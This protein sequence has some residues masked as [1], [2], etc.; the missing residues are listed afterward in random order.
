MYTKLVKK[1]FTK[2]LHTIWQTVLNRNNIVSNGQ[3]PSVTSARQLSVTFIYPN[4]A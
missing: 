3:Q 4:V 1:M 2:R